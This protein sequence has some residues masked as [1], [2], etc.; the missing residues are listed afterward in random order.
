LKKPEI[1]RKEFRL[2]SEGTA[3]RNPREHS[4]RFHASLTISYL[5]KKKKVRGTSVR[6]ENIALM[7]CELQSG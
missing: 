3:L 4:Q 6:G 5:T 2:M 1:P 7:S